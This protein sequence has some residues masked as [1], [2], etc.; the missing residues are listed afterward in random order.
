MI[1]RKGWDGNYVLKTIGGKLIRAG[2]SILDFRGRT[3]VVVGG[4]APH[5]QRSQGLVHVQNGLTR[6][7]QPE[8]FYPSV[9]ECTWVR[10]LAPTPNVAKVTYWTGDTDQADDPCIFTAGI[11]LSA[12]EGYGS[13]S[14]TWWS[15]IECHHVNAEKA[16]A[17]RDFVLAAIEEKLARGV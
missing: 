13:T 5:D 16:N 3:W 6:Q 1:T 10:A 17:L 15:Q 11:N 2:E 4:E 8:A 7:G 12:S 9:I 14:G